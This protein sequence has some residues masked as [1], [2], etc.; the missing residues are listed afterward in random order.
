[1]KNVVRMSAL[2]LVLGSAAQAET[3]KVD[4]SRYE[5]ILDRQIFGVTPAVDVPDVPAIDPMTQKKTEQMQKQIRM[6]GVRMD[7]LGLRVAFIDMGAKPPRNYYQ[8]VGEPP[9]SDGYEVV[10][11]DYEA[12]KAVLRKDGIEFPISMGNASGGVTTT[13]SKP[14]ASVASSGGSRR[15]MSYSERLRQRR[16]A[17]RHR[18]VEPPK[19]QGEDLKKHLSEYNM[20]LIRKGAPPLPI[21]LTQ[22]QDAKL[23]EEGVL[24]PQE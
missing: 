18:H 7:D 2:L 17:F 22:E 14:S 15:T 5:V 4:F 20:E 3:V 11:A 10:S 21:P 6:C 23:V 24:P 1:M 19:L 8:G 9:P 13:S 16:E 12:E